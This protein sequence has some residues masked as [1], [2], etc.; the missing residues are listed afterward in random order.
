MKKLLYL[1]LA[2]LMILPLTVACGSAPE[3]DPVAVADFSVISYSDAYGDGAVKDEAMAIELYKGEVTAYVVEGNDMTL[4]DVI[5]GYVYDKGV[6][7]S[8]NEAGTIYESL[9]GYT[10]DGTFFWNF[11]VNGKEA[12]LSAKVQPTDSIKVCFEK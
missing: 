10:A 6:D 9:A 7:A 12:S 3:G 8:T 1:A 4:K 11:Y 5:E 2:V